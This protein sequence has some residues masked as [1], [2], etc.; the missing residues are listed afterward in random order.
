MAYYYSE[1]GSSLQE[2]SKKYEKAIERIELTK[3]RQLLENALADVIAFFD[4]TNNTTKKRY[5]EN[6]FVEMANS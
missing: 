2:A 4:N 6:K 5:Y 1:E 3:D